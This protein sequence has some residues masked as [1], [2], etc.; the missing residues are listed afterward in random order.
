MSQIVFFRFGISVEQILW[1][2]WHKLIYGELI[3]TER[4]MMWFSADVFFKSNC[5]Y[6]VTFGTKLLKVLCNVIVT[7]HYFDKAWQFLLRFVLHVQSVVRL[8]IVI[9][10]IV[11][12]VLSNG[13]FLL[14]FF[15][16]D[17]L[18]SLNAVCCG[19]V[20]KNLACLIFCTKIQKKRQILMHVSLRT[21]HLNLR[22]V[23]CFLF[24]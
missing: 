10:L 7:C 22:G 6:T 5:Y 11:L 24:V 17:M 13:A 2:S 14:G 23:G 20:S 3:R 21:N 19:V 16:V 9:L 12:S 4:P 1:Y 18:S 15:L 8:G